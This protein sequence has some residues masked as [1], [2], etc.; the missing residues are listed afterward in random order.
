MLINKDTYE[1]LMEEQK[2]NIKKINQKV[3]NV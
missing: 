3:K 2:R 1:A